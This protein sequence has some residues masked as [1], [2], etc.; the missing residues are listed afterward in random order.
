MIYN[1]RAQGVPFV[2]RTQLA[3]TS[4]L[5]LGSGTGVLAALL[6][7]LSKS[8]T[9]TDIFSLLPLIDKNI[10]RNWPAKTNAKVEVRELDWTWSRKELERNLPSSGEP[11]DLV[12]AVDCL[13]NEALVQPFVDTLDALP[14]R[15]VI[16]VSE[17][18]SSDVMQLFLER[19]LASGRWQIWRVGDGTNERG[20]LGDSQVVWVGWK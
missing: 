17:L 2:D 5:E 7:P 20:L 13:Y 4:V 15:A 19:W 14:C 3:Y 12:V 1:H 16:V 8:W 6:G 10:K 18:R 11:W 9:A